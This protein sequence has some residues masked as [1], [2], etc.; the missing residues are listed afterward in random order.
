MSGSCWISPDKGDDLADGLRIIE[1]EIEDV[2][3]A[4]PISNRAWRE[5]VGEVCDSL[6]IGSL[7]CS[8][9]AG[10]QRRRRTGSGA[11]GAALL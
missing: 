11:A 1:I 8:D 7:A 6:G 3:R 5:A 10:W 4:R 2:G 9:D